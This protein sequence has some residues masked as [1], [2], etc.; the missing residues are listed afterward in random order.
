MW[1]ILTG[2]VLFAIGF[3]VTLQIRSA[4]RSDPLGNSEKY[5]EMGMT[6]SLPFLLLGI[7]LVFVGGVASLIRT[8]RRS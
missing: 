2:L 8:F 4:A 5:V 6:Y 7:L 3:I 1:T